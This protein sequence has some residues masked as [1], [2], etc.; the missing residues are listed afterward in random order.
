MPI[1][2]TLIMIVWMLTGMVIFN[3]IKYYSRVQLGVI[4]IA[5]VICCIGIK[6]LASKRRE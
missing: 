3:E 4:S 2:L 1:Y 5:I 6:C